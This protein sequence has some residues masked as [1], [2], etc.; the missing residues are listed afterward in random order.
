MMAELR[1]VPLYRATTRT[2]MVLG[3]ERELTLILMILS[4]ALVLTSLSLEMTLIG[5]TT[6]FAGLF[7]LRQ[8]ARHDPQI[9]RIFLRYW[10]RHKDVYYP[11][12]ARPSSDGWL[13]PKK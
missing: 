3:A 6:W 13:P 7:L 9:S 2:L 12:A 8:L 10:V 5:A 1:R 11:A 4:G